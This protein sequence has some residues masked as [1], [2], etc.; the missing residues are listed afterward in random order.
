MARLQA[1]VKGNTVKRQAAIALRCIQ[2]LVKVQVHSRA[3]HVRSTLQN[4][5]VQK[6]LIQQLEVEAPAKKPEVSHLQFT[7]LSSK[8]Y[9][10]CFLADLACTEHTEWVV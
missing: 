10:N 2:A 8:S 4:Q 9:M 1:L 3:K 5:S 6:K 7:L